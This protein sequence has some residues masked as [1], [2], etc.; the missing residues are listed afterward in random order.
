MKAKRI[1]SGLLASLMIAGT[2]IVGV[3]AADS[4]SLPFDDVEKKWYYNAVETAYNEGIMTGKSDTKFDPTANIT[5]AEVVTAFARVACTNIDGYGDDL[6]FTDTKS[7]KW[8]S[9]SVGWAADNGI[10]K[11]RGDGRF[12]PSD[13]I[14]RAE[15]ASILVNFIN[16]MGIKLPDNPKLDRFSD[17]GTFANWMKAPIEAVRKNGLMQG[18]DG[19][20]NPKGS[21]MRAEV[22]QVI[23]NLLPDAGRTT[24]VLNGVSDYV[25]VADTSD[26][27]AVDAAER[28][29]YQLQYVTGAELKIVNST[30]A[31]TEKEI[32]IGSARKSGIDTDELTIDGYEIAL[33]GNKVYIDSATADGLYLGAVRFINTCTSGDDVRFTARTA[34]RKPHEYPV[35]KLMINGNDISKY[36]VYYPEN[37]S[38]N[39]LTAVDDLVKYI[40]K[41]TGTKL[42]K[43]TAKPGAYGIV[44]DET[45]VVIDGSV[46]KSIDNFKVKSE[47]NSIRLM[48][49][50]ER[51]AAYASYD[52][53]EEYLGCV[54]L[55]ENSDYVKP[56][57]EINVKDVDYTESPIFAIR[58][59]YNSAAVPELKFRD[60]SWTSANGIHTFAA[61]A[62]DFCKQYENQPCLLDEAVYEQVM[63]NVIKKIEEK[64]TAQMVSVSMNDNTNWCGCEK[65]APVIEEVG[66]TE[67]L[68]RFVN[69]VAEAVENKGYKDILIHT[70]AYTVA[71]E[72]PKTPPREN[73][74][75]QYAPIDACIS[76]PMN[77]E[78]NHSWS[79]AYSGKY[80]EE[81]GK[82]GCKMYLWTYNGDYG[83]PVPH[84]DICYKTMSENAKYYVECGVIGWLAVPSD[85][86]EDIFGDFGVL[87]NYLISKFMWDPYITEE[88]YVELVSDFMMGYY[89]A[90]WKNVY[91]AFNYYIEKDTGCHVLYESIRNRQVYWMYMIDNEYLVDL[92]DKAE[93]LAESYTVWKNIDRNQIQFNL[94]EVYA[95]FDALHDSDDPEEFMLSQ[96]MSKHLQ[97]KFNV[98]RVEYGSGMFLNMNI[99]EFHVNPGFWR[100]DVD[101]PYFV[102]KIEDL[103][104]DYPERPTYLPPLAR[105]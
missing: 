57:D 17:E 105:D 50:A 70:F 9:Y 37:A 98:Y 60:C 48:G 8:Y 6:G 1:I 11:G 92:M 101:P 87:R 31:E 29:R 43:S 81:W 13:L 7:G 30:T 40:E 94:M 67:Y 14:T 26:V 53:L 27:G 12:S 76:H 52:F 64:P 54:F 93:L 22:A 36:T 97:D 33:D 78:C 75:V 58:D 34:E 38:Q 44:V 21:A 25:I 100:A 10:V 16:Y 80:L 79:R 89:G 18:A 41:A 84:A 90:G 5:R 72:A 65:C 68:I 35:E 45:T 95:K 4:T 63:E 3:T 66:Y 51:G 96:T 83:G 85:D 19:K 56:A 2:A 88:E 23:S 15:L 47:G 49:S 103:T 74:I 77:A 55:S 42:P 71:L 69:R 104:V 24:V 73:V 28:I 32:V 82:T 102:G 20:F 59:N 62:P 61:L 39:T 86:R 46:N 91:E 99:G